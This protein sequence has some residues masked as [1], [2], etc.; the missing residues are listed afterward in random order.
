MYC[1]EDRSTGVSCYHTPHMYPVFAAVDI[2][3]ITIYTGYSD[4]WNIL[5]IKLNE[6]CFRPRFCTYKAILNRGQ[7]GLKIHWLL[8]FYY[9]EYPS[10]CQ[11]DSVYTIGQ[12]SDPAPGA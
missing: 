11:I 5:V 9:K 4:I 6:W 8:R 12:V 2:P 10:H 3:H 7:P 1:G